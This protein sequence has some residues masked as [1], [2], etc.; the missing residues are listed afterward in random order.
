MTRENTEDLAEKV[1]VVTGANGRVGRAVIGLLLASGAN[2]IAV[3]QHFLSLRTLFGDFIKKNRLFC[4]ES[5]LADKN[6]RLN[7]GFKV[8]ELHKNLY[9][10]INCAAFLGDR[11]VEGWST[12][13]QAQNIDIWPAVFEVSVTAIF[14][15][16]QIFEEQLKNSDDP[17]RIVNLGS[18]YGSYGPDWDLYQQVPAGNPAGYAAAKGAVI[19]LTTWLASTLGPDVT[20]NMV[21]PGGIFSGHT[22]EFRLKYEKKTIMGR[23]CTENDVAGAIVWLLSRNASYLTGQNIKVDGGWCLR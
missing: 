7:L 1:I 22:D 10:L 13:F 14:H 17:G 9:G 16:A 4:I 8:S 3:D 2:V 6:S 23:M 19:S 12:S 5:D 18:I 20:V 11:K 15:L 21:S